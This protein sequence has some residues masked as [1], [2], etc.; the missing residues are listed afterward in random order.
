MIKLKDLLKEFKQVKFI[1]QKKEFKKIDKI[2]RQAKFKEGQDFNYQ[3]DGPVLKLAVN[4]KLENKILA[5]LVKKGIKN[6]HGI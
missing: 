6:I 3:S 2:L 5:I 1:I 4:K